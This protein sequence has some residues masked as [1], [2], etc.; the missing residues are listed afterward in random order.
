MGYNEANALNYLQQEIIVNKSETIQ[1]TVTAYNLNITFQVVFLGLAIITTLATMY[2]MTTLSTLGA[3]TVGL[4]VLAA[5]IAVTYLLSVKASQQERLV[6]Q[7]LQ[8][9][10]L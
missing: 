4:P 6:A 5:T 7:L 8:K 2:F 3:I 9:S 1:K 10:I